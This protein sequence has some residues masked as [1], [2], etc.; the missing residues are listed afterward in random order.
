MKE[1]HRLARCLITETQIFGRGA[2]GRRIHSWCR[3]FAHVNEICVQML[4]DD[5]GHG[6][7]GRWRV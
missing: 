2:R 5:L 3:D 6:I 7:N 4:L 1:W